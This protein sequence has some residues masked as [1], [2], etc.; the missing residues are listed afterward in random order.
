MKWE[1]ETVKVRDAVGKNSRLIFNLPRC[2]ASSFRCKRSQGADVVVMDF[3]A[4]WCPPCHE[5][6]PE[7]KALTKKYPTEKLVLI[8]VSADK[9]EN[10]W[11][12]FVAKKK[13]DWAQYRDPE[14]RILE[15]FGIS[16]FP[17]YLVMD[18]DGVIKERMTGLNPQR[19]WCTA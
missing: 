6:V 14:G 15:P 1:A 10:A 8:S 5:S 7:L 3:W 4:T 11:K 9:D 17:T 12:G 19:A 18:G 2:R 16:S 13:M